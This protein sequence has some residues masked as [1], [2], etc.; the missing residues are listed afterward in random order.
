M[1]IGLL[2]AD[3]GEAARLARAL[4]EAGYRPTPYDC[5]V[6]L[7]QAVRQERFDLLLMRW[8]G[9]ALSGVALVHR[10]R[11]RMAPAPGMILLVD[12]T[13]PGGIGEIA[14]AALP[15]PCKEGDLLG[16]IRALAAQRGLSGQNQPTIGEL[17]FDEQDT[18]VEVNGMPVQ[19]TAKE[20]AL[21]QLL[22]RHVGQPLSRDEIMASVWGRSEN[23]GSRTLD[24]HVAQV[25]KRLLLRPEHGWRLSSVYGFGYRLDR[26]EGTV[27]GRA[28]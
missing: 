15:D 24:A 22:M 14:D 5:G 1:R 28:A 2:H 18:V 10:L 3:P 11:G 19:L 23:P 8:D 16:C 21:A 12:E 17:R 27:K 25:R 20:Y 9:K 26:V 13:A 7:E 6:T 4:A